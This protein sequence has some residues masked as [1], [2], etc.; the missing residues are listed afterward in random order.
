MSSSLAHQ[1]LP[2]IQSRPS[3]VLVVDDEPSFAEVA[4]EALLHAGYHAA[5]APDG[6]MAPSGW[7]RIPTSICYSPTS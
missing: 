1:P 3:F 4:M 5:F 2:R 6:A 7:R